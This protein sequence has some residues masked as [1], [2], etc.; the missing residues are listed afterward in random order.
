MLFCRGK[1][2]IKLSSG[3]AT[4]FGFA[5]NPEIGQNIL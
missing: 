4:A 5:M 3:L 1:G 2:G